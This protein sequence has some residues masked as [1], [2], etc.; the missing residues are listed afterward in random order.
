[1]CVVGGGFD[2]VKTGIVE[3]L[4]KLDDNEYTNFEIKISNKILRNVKNLL[5]FNR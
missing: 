5:H 2:V 3:L 4:V 1:M